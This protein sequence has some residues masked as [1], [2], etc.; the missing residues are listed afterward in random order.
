MNIEP[1]SHTIAHAGP[2]TREVARDQELLQVLR[3][4]GYP[5][6]YLLQ[7]V[8][9][10]DARCILKIAEE[11]QSLGY[12]PTLRSIVAVYWDESPV[13]PW[14]F[15]NDPYYMRHGKSLFPMNMHELVDVLERPNVSEV[16]LAGSQ[17]WGKT[18]VAG[19]GIAYDLYRLLCHRNPQDFYGL[20]EGTTMALVNVSITADNA[21]GVLGGY[22]IKAITTSPWFEDH[23]YKGDK[24][25]RK[26]RPG[27]FPEKNVIYK[28][29][30]SSE[31]SVISWNIV[32]G[33]MDEANF[34]IGAK[35][36]RRSIEAG[37]RDQAQVIWNSMARRGSMTAVA[38]IPAKFWLISSAQFPGDFVERRIKE[39]QDAQDDSVMVI[40]HNSW[41]TK[42][43]LPEER[44]PFSRKYFILFIGD[45]T[46]RSRIVEEPAEVEEA[47]DLVAHD[48]VAPVGCEYILV[49]VEFKKRFIADL[50]GSIRDIVGKSILAKN[51]FITDVESLTRCILREDL[52]D[53]PGRQHPYEHVE[54][55]IASAS[56]VKA[57]L[58]PITTVDELVRPAL[59]PHE[60]RFVHGDLAKNLDSAAVAIGHFGGYKSIPLERYEVVLDRWGNPVIQ[61]GAPLLRLDRFIERRPITIID[62]MMKFLPPKNGTISPRAIREVVLALERLMGFA[63]IELWTYDQYQSQDSIDTL[64]ASGYTA[65]V[66]SVDT[67]PDAYMELRESLSDDR[68]STYP[69]P[70]FIQDMTSLEWIPAA[71]KVDHREGGTKDVSDCVAAVCH[72]VH[73]HYQTE[74]VPLAAF[75]DVEPI[76]PAVRARQEFERSLGKIPQQSKFD[77]LA[78]L[79]RP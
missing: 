64:N 70:P 46:R 52:G 73:T 34:M 23:F 9:H 8:S 45:E 7:D 59:H 56:L 47:Y 75:R 6:D 33:G 19:F 14:T 11:F 65:E 37:E 60:P 31:F 4:S 71:N 38:Q 22:I 44:C 24:F 74:R 66:Y 42:M 2:A 79:L 39:V 61:D 3:S 28:A 69:Y 20:G 68:M 77:P 1:T 63:G 17:R 55:H 15:L 5:L 29:G 41:E 48:F 62:F 27:F 12:S 49:P 40:R 32:G 53:I 54:T 78:G 72:H 35:R 57:G 36:T 21:E 51:P 10:E 25:R 76:S 67:K 30:N 18:Y 58:L 43:S 50:F 16:I 26:H 13:D